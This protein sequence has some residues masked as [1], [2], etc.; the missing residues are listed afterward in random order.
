MYIFE[1]WAP[2]GQNF[3]LPILYKSAVLFL[4]DFNPDKCWTKRSLFSAF[5]HEASLSRLEAPRDVSRGSRIEI[6]VHLFSAKSKTNLQKRRQLMNDAPYSVFT[7][8]FTVTAY[9]IYELLTFIW[10]T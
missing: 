7:L 1:I 3:R 2:G 10:P 5:L 8:V 9:G 4:K 6:K